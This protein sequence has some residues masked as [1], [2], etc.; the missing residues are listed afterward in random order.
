MGLRLSQRHGMAPMLTCCQVCGGDTNELLLLGAS[1]DKVCQE[2]LGQPY[3]G[4]SCQRI[5]HG[6]CDSC[7]G[8]LKAGAAVYFCRQP[9][10]LV[11]LSAECVARN[12]LINPGKITEISAESMVN[13]QRVFNP[14]PE[15]ASAVVT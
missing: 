9:P 11:M 4:S 15:E 3:S 1:A 2:T 7:Q 12:S 10:Q 8:R 14:Q 6:L 5:P 13:L